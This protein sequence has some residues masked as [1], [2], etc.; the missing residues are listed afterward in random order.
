MSKYYY[1]FPADSREGKQLR[2]FHR[3]AMKAEREA[4]RYAKKVGALAYYE[5][6]NGFAGGVGCVT[7]PQGKKVN[8]NVWRYVAK[9][10]ENGERLYIPNTRVTSCHRMLKAG[11]TVPRDS[12]HRIWQKAK[13][14]EGSTERKVTYLD[15]APAI[16]DAPRADREAA[17][18][19]ERWRLKLPVVRLASFYQIVHADMSAIDGTAAPKKI[20]ESTPV[21]FCYH[22][23]YYIGL[24]YP[25]RHEG[26]E[27]T[28]QYTF[29]T[30]KREL[31]FEE[32]M[33]EEDDDDLD[34]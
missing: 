24:D 15:I 25:I 14:I 19:A 8:Q 18:Q 7:F 28:D 12:A 1:K 10:S 13:P 23:Y 16:A 20:Q 29:N 5:D 30:T 17:V 6:P 33:K 26:F 4:E 27:A 2:S 22:G 34:S 31:L 21:F 3:A 32:K 11:E 9:Q